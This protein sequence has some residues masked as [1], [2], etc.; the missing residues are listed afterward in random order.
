[1]SLE[2]VANE[3]VR[4]PSANRVLA[5]SQCSYTPPCPCDTH[6]LA[7]SRP[8]ALP[9]LE[10]ASSSTGNAAS[11]ATH[12][13][14]ALSRA[15]WTTAF[16]MARQRACGSCARRP[17]QQEPQS[18]KSG[19]HH[20]HAPMRP[21]LNAQ[22]PAPSRHLSPLQ[23]QSRASSEC[24]CPRDAVGI[25]GS[26]SAMAARYD[27]STAAPAHTCT[28]Q[29]CPRN[30]WQATANDTPDCLTTPTHIQ[31]LAVVNICVAVRCYLRAGQVDTA[32]FDSSVDNGRATPPSREQPE[33]GGSRVHG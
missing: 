11:Q 32:G 6:T 30:Q 33:R 20:R 14:G 4:T 12:R 31:G 10:A 7:Q 28:G 1:M 5:L 9:P 25:A 21:V 24:L 26:R 23:R 22:P 29:R 16:V 13:P 27:A 17:P 15:A 3:A 8:R 18:R 2:A 19:S